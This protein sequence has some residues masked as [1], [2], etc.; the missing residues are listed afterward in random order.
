MVTVNK[1]L[2]KSIHFEIGVLIY[3]SLY[4]RMWMRFIWIRIESSG[5]LL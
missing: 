4:G 3:I 5:R 1:L 2:L